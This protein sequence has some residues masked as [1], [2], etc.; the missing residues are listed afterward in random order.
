MSKFV[1]ASKEWIF[2][3]C[4]QQNEFQYDSGQ[5]MEWLLG[6]ADINSWTGLLD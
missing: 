1:T 5:I 4:K 6:I 2:L 3:D